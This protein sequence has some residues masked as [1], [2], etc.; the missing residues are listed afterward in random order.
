MGTPP[1][2]GV[3]RQQPPVAALQPVPCRPQLARPGRLKISHDSVQLAESP[4]GQRRSEP[5]VQ[6]PGIQA[7]RREVAAQRRRGPVPVGIR[8]PHPIIHPFGLPLVGPSPSW[9][10][11]L[12]E[13]PQPPRRYRRRR[14]HPVDFLLQPQRAAGS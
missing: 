5:L 4:C 7:A 13:Q 8:F 10:P 12:A 9:L 6:F 14:A 3:A 2:G 1:G 11:R